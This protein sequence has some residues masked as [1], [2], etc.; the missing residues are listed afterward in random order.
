MAVVAPPPPK[1]NSDTWGPGNSSIYR[2]VPPAP[3]PM[4]EI[5]SYS[6]P[7]PPRQNGADMDL[8]PSGYA[9]SY[10]GH[11]TTSS[12]MSIRPS[13]DAGIPSRERADSFSN[14]IK[15][16]R[17]LSTPTAGTPPSQLSV[18]QSQTAQQTASEQNALALASEKRRNKLGYHRTSVACGKFR[19]TPPKRTG[20]QAVV[21]TVA[22]DTVGG[23]RSGVFPPKTTSSSDV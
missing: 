12:G 21:L 19:W 17:S 16:K 8:P 18:L 1:S 15:L 22:K 14:S 5:M 2:A 3:A 6:Y 20:A 7:E 23:A 11:P 10:P 13:P 4:T 9:P